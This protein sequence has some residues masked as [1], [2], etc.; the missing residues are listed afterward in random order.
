M[1]DRRR[2]ET[3]PALSWAKDPRVAAT[4]GCVTTGVLAAFAEARRRA[5]FCLAAVQPLLPATIIAA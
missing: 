4:L 5:M 2:F 3:A 1:P